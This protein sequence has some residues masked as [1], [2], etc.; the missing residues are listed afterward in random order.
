MI[1]RVNYFISNVLTSSLLGDVADEVGNNDNNSRRFAENL[2]KSWK[3]DCNF[4]V[5]LAFLT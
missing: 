4:H 5:Q 2:I 1:D 3:S